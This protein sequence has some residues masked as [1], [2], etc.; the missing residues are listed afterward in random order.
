MISRR[1]LLGTTLAMPFG[2]SAPVTTSSALR[3]IARARNITFGTAITA[4]DITGDASYRDLI[5]REC[6]IVTPGIEAKFG[7]T[8]PQEGIFRFERMDRVAAF[9]H[10]AGIH[11]HMHNL[12]WAVGL[13]AWAVAALGQGHGRDIMRR[14]IA[15]VAGRYRGRATSWDVV[16][17]PIDPR[18]PAD[19]RGICTTPWRLGVGAD[20]IRDALLDAHAADP[21]AELMIND[22]DLEYDS[23]DRD[24]KRTQYLRLI[25]DLL[26]RDTPLHGFGLEAHLKPWLKLAETPYRRFLHELAG[27]GLKLH[28]TEFDVN[29]R[30]FPAGIAQRDQA[31][32][33]A[34]RRY[35]DIALD[36]PAV[37][38]LITWGLS[39]RTTWLNRDPI[40]HRTD[41][42]AA[43]PLPY[44]AALAAKPM[45]MAIAQSLLAARSRPA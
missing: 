45:R 6:A 26:R 37:R 11:L 12:I 23:P 19:A 43:R 32:A 3:D 8:E 40:G 5:A 38:T 13:P 34:A 29:D 30:G 7:S 44:D 21:H 18:W 1:R 9:A 31:V 24:K 28:I 36:E 41:G 20:Y 15:T 16:N 17:E 2:A 27:F 33:Q 39:D 10:A 42:L 14:H 4:A 25:E 35:L 22:D